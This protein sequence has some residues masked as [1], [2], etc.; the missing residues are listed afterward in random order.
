MNVFAPPRAQI[1]VIHP[2]PQLVVEAL[3]M[4]G[5]AARVDGEAEG[6]ALAIIAVGFSGLD[7]LRTAW[8]L[9]Q[10]SA[11]LPLLA[12]VPAWGRRL[13]L[14]AAALNAAPT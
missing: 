11:T 9:R 5:H 2:Q 8:T 4:L 7:G 10:R 1:L 13:F 3:A 6:C 14:D 12:P